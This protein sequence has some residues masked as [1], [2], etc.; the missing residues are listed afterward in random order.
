MP[1]GQKSKLRAR[2]KRQ[3]TQGKIRNNISA[4][5]KGAEGDQPSPSTSAA[6]EGTA[7]GYSGAHVLRQL[8]EEGSVCS[9][10]DIAGLRISDSREEDEEEEEEEEEQPCTS[11]AALYIASTR[12]DPLVRRTCMVVQFLLEKYKMKEPITQAALLK[13]VSKRYKDSF[14]EV[15]R[16]VSERMELVFGLELR[17]T[18]PSGHTYILISKLGEGDE[19]CGGGLPKMGLLMTLLGVIFM[20]GNR[21]L[22]EEIWDFLSVLGIF[23]GRRHLIF[24]EPRRLITQE[25]VRERYL[26]YQLIPHSDPPVYE[27][28][29][30]PRAY[31]ET[32]KMKVLEV[33]AKIN[34]SIPSNF[35]DM[36]EEALR[37][38]E[39]RARE[40]AKERAAKSRRPPKPASNNPSNY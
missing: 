13:I 40:R 14:P 29:W 1:R 20:K 39:E 18:Y 5:T 36:Y 34:D 7:A 6:S 9:E 37:D 25:F 16:R 30:G 12:K 38:E 35:P 24:G 11:R 17:E 19:S 8:E 10:L 26:E 33:I 3:Q 23:P 4:E 21:A 32:T 2:M 15:I 31:T 28:L 22:E 27:F